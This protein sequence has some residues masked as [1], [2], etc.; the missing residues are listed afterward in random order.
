MDELWLPSRGNELRDQSHLGWDMHPL[1]YR[2]DATVVLVDN[3]DPDN[4]ACALAAT[5]PLLGLNVVAVVVTGRPASP[6]PDRPIDYWDFEYSKR[7]LYENAQRMKGFLTRAGREIPVFTG[8]IPPRTIIPHDK[9]ID[10]RELDVHRDMGGADYKPDGNFEDATTYLNGLSHTVLNAVVG[11]PL[12][13]I[14]AWQEDVALAQRF[15]RGSTVMQFGV[16]EPTYPR[17][18]VHGGTQ[19]NA[20]A[21]PIAARTFLRRFVGDLSV[22][23]RNLTKGPGAGFATIEEFTRLDINHELKEVYRL[24]GEMVLQDVGELYVHDV[25]PPLVLSGYPGYSTM[26]NS[27]AP[28]YAATQ[29]MRF[30]LDDGY[31]DTIAFDRR[32]TSKEGVGVLNLDDN[33]YKVYDVVQHRDV[34]SILPVV[35]W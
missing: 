29:A 30:V 4:M 1:E 19:F 32:S 6:E 35:L 33:L 14:S 34:K 5:N 9:H 20:Y 17:P 12:S 18:T 23:A 26:D 10:E 27:C 21:D 16:I 28:I 31:G 13:E 8:L 7:L 11:G 3:V 25:H 24:F 15:N 22:V 2:K